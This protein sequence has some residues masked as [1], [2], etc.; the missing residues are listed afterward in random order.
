MFNAGYYEKLVPKLIYE[1]ICNGY[2]IVIRVLERVDYIGG[3]FYRDMQR[4]AFAE[5]KL[6]EGYQI[7]GLCLYQLPEGRWI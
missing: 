4:L 7:N 5:M 3:N 2:S 1:H 6:I